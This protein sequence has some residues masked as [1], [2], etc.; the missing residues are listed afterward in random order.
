MKKTTAKLNKVFNFTL[1]K[2]VVACTLAAYLLFF[3]GKAYSAVNYENFAPAPFSNRMGVGTDI[4]NKKEI[5]AAAVKKQE[6]KIETISR[7]NDIKGLTY[8]DLSLKQISKDVI[9]EMDIES[10]EI[11]ADL[12]ILYNNAIQKSETIKYAIYKLSNPEE[13]KPDESAI[14]RLLRPI[15]SFSTIAGT[16]LSANPYM[17]SGALIGGG[18]MNAFSGDDKEANYKF[19]KVNDADMV[20]LVRK[21]DELQKNLLNNYVNY[22]T[23]KELLQLSMQ[24]LENRR[25]VYNAMQTGAKKATREELIVADTYYRNAQNTV[26]KAQAEYNLS[27]V[28][29]ENL[30]GKEALKEIESK[31]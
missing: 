18:L 24:N 2:Q 30:A 1:R 31:K 8:A 16:A 27:R 11:L 25:K 12:S 17:A 10:P 6:K 26:K 14:K 3:A 20:L 13:N 22:I 28:I 29:L 21:I 5:Q 19:T 7:A 15:A 9:E 23:Q 4:E